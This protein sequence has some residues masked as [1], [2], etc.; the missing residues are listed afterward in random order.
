MKKLL[1]M[2]LC[3]AVICTLTA[4]KDTSSDIIKP[5]VSS[6]SK[7]TPYKEPTHTSHDTNTVT[8]ESSPATSKSSRF[9]YISTSEVEKDYEVEDD[10]GG[11]SILRYRGEGGK[12]NIPSVIG[13]KTVVKIDEHAFRGSEITN[14]VIPSSVVT[15]ETHAFSGCDK[16]ESLTISEGVEIID[17][18]AFADCPKLALVSLPDSIKEIGSGSFRN[19][20]S[21]LLTYKGQTYTITN[22]RDLYDIF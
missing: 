15:I 7:G 18:Y 14:V 16:L 9:N 17:D 6:A 4:C 12:V 3:G 19:C 11:V 8:A 10:I 1:T 22:V 5:A 2:L 13:G 21:L 20:P